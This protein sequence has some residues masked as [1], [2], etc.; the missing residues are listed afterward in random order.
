MED[1]ASQLRDKEKKDAKPAL[2]L[3]YFPLFSRNLSRPE[4]KTVGHEIWL[5][6]LLSI[7]YITGLC[8]I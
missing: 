2:F 3:P 6:A 7:I 5:F 4:T 8:R 1:E